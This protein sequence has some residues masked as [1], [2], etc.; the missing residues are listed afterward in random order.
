MT[1]GQKS[2][3]FTRFNVLRSM[4]RHGEHGLDEKRI[5]RALSLAQTTGYQ[6]DYNT[7]PERCL[8]DDHRYRHEAGIVCKHRIRLL[9]AS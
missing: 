6:D 8:C 4:A 7:T 9:I 1:T 3:I 5:N 2:H